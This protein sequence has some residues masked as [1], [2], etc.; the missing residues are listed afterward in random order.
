MLK[1]IAGL[2]LTIFGAAA[3]D[4]QQLPQPSPTQPQSQQL[5][6]PTPVEQATPLAQPAPSKSPTPAIEEANPSV[7]PSPAASPTPAESPP[8]TLENLERAI[9][10]QQPPVPENVNPAQPGMHRFTNQ[11]VAAVLRVLAE[12]AQMNYVEPPINPEERI[13]VTLTNMTP[14]QAFYA[15]AEARGFKVVT[16]SEGNV[17]TLRRAD[18]VTPSYYETRRFTLRYTACED[19]L[20]PVAGYLGIQIKPTAPNNPA[21][22]KP[23]DIQ[24]GAA[25]YVG[26]PEVTGGAQGGIQTLYSAGTEQSTPRFISGLPF[27]SPLSQASNGNMVWPERASNSI[28]ARATAEE[29]DGLAQQIRIWDRPEDQI[30]INTYVVEVSTNDDLF[31]GVDWSN[32]LGQQ[33]ATF[34]LTGNVGSPANTIFS[35]SIAGAFFKSGLILQ[36]PNVQATI[37]A[38]TQRGKLK[39]T[40]SPVTYTRTGEPVQIRS[41]QYQTFFLQTAATANVQATNTPYTFTTGLTIDIVPRILRGSII[42]LKINPALSTQAGTTQS[43]AIPGTNTTVAVPVIDTRSATADV[44][45]RSGDAAVIGG[46]TQ[47]TDNLTTNGIPGFR[48]IPLLGYLFN[49][50]QKNRDRTNLVII[51]WPRIVKGTFQ[52]NDRV[53]TDEADMVNKLRDLPGEPPPIPCGTEGKRPTSR[54]GPTGKASVYYQQPVKSSSKKQQSSKKQPSAKKWWWPWQQKQQQ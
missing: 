49:T 52:R 23:N 18:I 6:S 20:Q 14:T 41:V 10:N 50:R 48:K 13:S 16:A 7:E 29:L 19:L 4:A 37:R 43:P 28:M 46:I 9:P 51:V 21:Y 11:P 2:S 5:P 24:Q 3:A 1:L 54:Q 32:T 40:N 42:D 39:S 25:A 12:E 26:A 45:V 22:P 31:G 30:Q 27:D 47:D 38:L 33:G 34:S 53:G 15:V 35:Q 17:I 44:Q 36:F 8:Q